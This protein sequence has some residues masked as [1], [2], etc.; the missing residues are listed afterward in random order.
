MA[1]LGSYVTETAL[2]NIRKN[3]RLV[4]LLQAIGL[5]IDLAVFLATLGYESQAENA[6]NPFSVEI[7]AII[8]GLYLTLPVGS[9][10]ATSSK[11]P[12][13]LYLLASEIL[14]IVATAIGVV[15]LAVIFTGYLN[16][17]LPLLFTAGYL[18]NFP[19]WA[20][21][22][23]PLSRI[24]QRK[25]RGVSVGQYGNLEGVRME[26]CVSKISVLIRYALFVLII[27]IIL[28]TDFFLARGSAGFPGGS[29]WTFVAILAIILSCAIFTLPVAQ[30]LHKR[31]GWQ[32]II[33]DTYENGIL[34]W[35]DSRGFLTSV[36]LKTPSI[37]RLEGNQVRLAM[38]SRGLGTDMKFNSD[39]DLNRFLRILNP[40]RLDAKGL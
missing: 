21:R 39:S 13:E 29:N 8:L 34:W 15:A 20:G 5:F 30:I 16:L 25:Q 28:M 35:Y 31:T 17:T 24:S 14:T 9:I 36:E 33:L 7:R 10:L 27:S 11:D 4:N 18:L 38:V 37:T 3:I 26:M 23:I 6:S 19:V 32:D 1:P 22:V 2:A 12:K 40:I